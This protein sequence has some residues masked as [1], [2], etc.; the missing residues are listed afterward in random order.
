MIP[1]VGQKSIHRNYLKH[2]SII[3]NAI[4]LKEKRVL[5]VNITNQTAF[6]SII[7][8]T[9]TQKLFTLGARIT[10]P[11]ELFKCVYS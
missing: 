2:F 11:T 8:N 10:N 7:K 4:K 1:L 9:V 5:R 6:S 3:N